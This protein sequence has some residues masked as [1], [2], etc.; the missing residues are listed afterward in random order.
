MG[1]RSVF[2][3]EFDAETGLIHMGARD[4]DPE[5]GRFLQEDP[6]PYY[7]AA[8][9]QF[10]YADGVGELGNAYQ[11]A[12]NNPLKYIDPLGL[13]SLSVGGYTPLGG[14]GIIIG[15]NPNGPG[16]LNGGG[17]ITFRLGAGLGGGVNYNPN[18]GPPGGCNG[19]GH[20]LSLGGF[21]QAGVGIGPF[22]A[23]VGVNGGGY[24]NSNSGFGGY[25][26]VSPQW[27]A[28]WGTGLGVGAYGGAEVSVY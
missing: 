2:A 13:W 4:Y 7:Y 17:F 27:G 15:S 24:W 1:S 26:G 5:T 8:I 6:I 28:R 19:N 3:R 23:G 10:A 25:G 11:Y 20:R 14:G 16:L 21:G 12:F 9:N 18:G 22:N